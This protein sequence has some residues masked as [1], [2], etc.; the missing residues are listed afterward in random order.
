MGGWK[1]MVRGA[2]RNAQILALFGGAGI[3]TGCASN[4]NVDVEDLQAA[5]DGTGAVEEQLT[6]KTAELHNFPEEDIAA[7]EA[8][9][10]AEAP[11]L[12]N[13]ADVG[14][15][16]RIGAGDTLSFRSYDDTTLNEDIVVRYDGYISL[17]LIADIS[18]LSTSREEATERVRAAYE[19]FFIDPQISLSVQNVSSKS[20]YVIGDVEQPAEYPYVRPITLLEAIYNAG[21]QRIN[22]QGGDSFVGAQGQLVKAFIIR[23]HG[24]DRSV[25]EYDLR[26]LEKPGS[27]ASESPVYP[28]DIIY[29]PEGVNLVYLI[30][31]VRQPSVRELTPNMTLVHLLALSGGY[32]TNSARLREVIIMREI[33]E[34]NTEVMSV[35]LRKI[36]RGNSP[37]V[38]LMAGDIVYL[39][40]RKL[41][42]LQTFVGQFTGSISPMLSL[43]NQAFETY[44][45]ERR[46][47]L[48]Y[49]NDDNF[50]QAFQTGDIGLLS[51]LLRDVQGFSAIALP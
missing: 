13:G 38:P 2:Y 6:V 25:T 20:Y 8:R 27:H 28:G 19:E 36:L 3:L 42:R 43:Y 48:L 44:Y 35:N 51:Q 5:K 4:G 22:T 31:E 16:Y 39:P 11:T 45:T 26:D 23:N 46:L 29:V 49:D 10:N 37:D 50:G 32:I 40:E 47:R 7:A 12:E 24:E 9:A 17:P 14:G 30:G 41:L 34:E 21:G 33:D 18:V 1:R 15:E